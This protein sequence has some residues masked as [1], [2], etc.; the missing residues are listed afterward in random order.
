ME[1]QETAGQYDRDAALAAHEVLVERVKA[2]FEA[3]PGDYAFGRVRV[4]RR[5]FPCGLPKP[6]TSD[7]VG[8]AYEVA[9]DITPYSF[10][11]SVAFVLGDGMTLEDV[12][13]KMTDR[14]E[15]AGYSMAALLLELKRRAED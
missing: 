9:A 5:A 8:V 15:I 7:V 11:H 3:E 2:L 10:T 13:A 14:D 12:K 1:E 4:I 6:G